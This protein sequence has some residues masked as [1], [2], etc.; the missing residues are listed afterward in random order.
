MRLSPQLPVLP[1][2]L[3]EPSLWPGLPRRPPSGLREDFGAA[4]ADRAGSAGTWG[5]QSSGL[6][7]GP[8]GRTRWLPADEMT[9]WLPS[10]SFQSEKRSDTGSKS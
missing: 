3:Q 10:L 6:P 4:E 7:R 2:V 5:Q 9:S 1:W 8:Q